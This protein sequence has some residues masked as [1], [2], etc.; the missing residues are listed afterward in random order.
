VKVQLIAAALPPQLD[1]IGD[2]SALLAAELAKRAEVTVLSGGGPDATPIPGVRIVHAF[3]AADPASVSGIVEPILQA[4]PDWLLLQYNPFSYGKW[5]RNL[6]LP[7]ALRRLRRRLP[8]TRLAVMVHE[9]YVPVID[10][11]FAVMTTWQRW[12]LRTLARAAD[13][14]FG[15]IE[16]F[17]QTLQ[18]WFAPAPIHHLP[19]GANI[20]R[21]N[22]S[23]AEARARLGLAPEALVLGLFGTAHPSRL[24]GLVRETVATICKSR[25]ETVLHYIGPSVDTVRETFAG[26]PLTIGGPLPAEEVSRRFAAM[27]LYLAPFIDG[28]S[29]RRGSLMAALQHGVPTVGTRGPFTDTVFDR[30]EGRALLLADVNDPAGF[31]A[32]ALRLTADAELRCRMGVAA[33]ELYDREFDW[34][35]VVGRMLAAMQGEAR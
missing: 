34:E 16:R 17:V 5:G 4:R 31:Q 27:D 15:S 19:V 29:T 6:Q 23:R 1:G 2:Y 9:P 26:L 18:P 22:I 12:Q 25:P 35:P 30:E 8:Q 24:L 11:K 3:S 7:L 13:L 20:P 14:G 32:Q 21:V 10:W 28:V 33:R